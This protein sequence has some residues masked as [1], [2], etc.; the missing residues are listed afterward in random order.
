[1]KQEKVWDAIS[2]PWK[3]YRVKSIEEAYEFLKNKKGKILDLGC[4]SGRN[5]VK[6]N[7]I[8]YGVDFSSEQLK[9]AR[10]YAKKTGIEAIMK[11]AEAHNLPFKNNFFDA[12]IFIATLHC[13]ESSKKRK[14]SLKEIY[15]VLKPEAEAMITVWDKDQPRFKKSKKE[16]ALPW[17]IGEKK[18][19]RYC[20]LY[21]K[22]EITRLIKS[23]GFEI[24][25]ILDKSVSD[26][27]YSKRNIIVYVK[28]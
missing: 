5:F 7:G 22:K 16:I 12:A 15:R 21:D 23:V 2:K 24:T 20:Y 6:I 14:K 4:G 1:M 27:R 13:I 28:K 25:K 3:T 9:Y 26:S 8:I 17:K 11:K 10:Q 19:M 18:Y